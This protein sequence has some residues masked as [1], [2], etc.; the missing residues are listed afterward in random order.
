MS[1]AK[2]QTLS[3]TVSINF[4]TGAIELGDLLL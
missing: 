1:T 4:S 3:E 2:A